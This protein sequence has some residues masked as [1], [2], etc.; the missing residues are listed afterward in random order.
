V[1]TV[2]ILLAPLALLSGCEAFSIGLTG[3][4][5]PPDELELFAQASP[6]ARAHVLFD[7]Y[8]GRATRSTGWADTAGAY[9]LVWIGPGFDE[10]LMNVDEVELRL[11]AVDAA[12]ERTER[13]PPPLELTRV[14]DE[15]G[16]VLDA[17]TFVPSTEPGRL[18]FALDGELY[19]QGPDGGAWART[20]L[21]QGV[22][23]DEASPERS[24]V[25]HADRTWVDV[26]EPDGSVWQP[27]VPEQGGWAFGPFDG[28]ELVR[29]RWQAELLCVDWVDLAS[30]SVGHTVCHTPELPV[31]GLDGA[32]SGSVNDVLFFIREDSG[33]QLRFLFVADRDGI[34]RRGRLD[35]TTTEVFG[36]YPED[37]QL[38]ALRISSAR[39]Q[40]HDQFWFA[41]GTWT[42]K[43]PLQQ[44]LRPAQVCDCPADSDPVDCRC[45]GRGVPTD[46]VGLVGVGQAWLTGVS[47]VD[48]RRRGFAQHVD[49][50]PTTQTTIDPEQP[51]DADWTIEDL[52]RPDGTPLV[53]IAPGY[54]AAGEVDL[55]A[56]TTVVDEQ[57]ET[58]DFDERGPILDE[59]VTY[60][61]TVE[62]CEPPDGHGT[63]EPVTLTWSTDEGAPA[64]LTDV[65]F[66]R[67]LALDPV[68]PD[69]PEWVHA[70]DAEILLLREKRG[71]TALSLSEAG[72]LQATVVDAPDAAPPVILRDGRRLLLD[73]G[74]VLDLDSGEVL[75]RLSLRGP[76]DGLTQR[77]QGRLL[78][79]DR[80]DGLRIWDLDADLERLLDVPGPRSGTLLDASD[81]GRV[82]LVQE[83]G[84]VWAR[85]ADGG[86][87][88][89]GSTELGLGGAW[90]S[91]DGRWALTSVQTASAGLRRM[92]HTAWALDG[93]GRGFRGA[94]RVACAECRGWLA[95]DRPSGGVVQY[96]SASSPVWVH[97]EPSGSLGGGW[98]LERTEIAS[99]TGSELKG[100]LGPT[101]AW[102]RAWWIQG[103]DVVGYDVDDGSVV[104]PFAAV[105]GMEI[106][107]AW[108]GPAWLSVEG[109]P[110]WRRNGPDGFERYL[111]AR[112]NRPSPLARGRAVLNGG[113]PHAVRVGDWRPEGTSITDAHPVVVGSRPTDQAGPVMA[114]WPCFPVRLGP[115]PER[116]VQATSWVC[117][118]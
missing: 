2:L 115:Q 75:T 33:W 109:G 24:L 6:G 5:V 37:P 7:V 22:V 66:G 29:L 11:I 73:G 12:G 100:S 74:D 79:E 112:S 88:D 108:H 23:P 60:T 64:P 101:D 86:Q 59:G 1:R 56:C 80:S 54:N 51:L 63:L 18:V 87:M 103:G 42:W 96:D 28:Q 110:D 116:V 62:G 68:D 105:S 118:R 78:V 70:V 84:R 61:F 34:E 57:G 50:S 99:G 92:T 41:D 45:I 46:H 44:D 98:S 52:P 81:D 8:D 107:R 4:E 36:L 39:G 104:R 55:T 83:T 102:G 117:A 93:S 21:P 67:G 13:E 69:A 49:L 43:K 65:V 47:T 77:G 30:R 82:R 111:Y 71:W 91:G 76:L 90:I 106:L 72:A 97:L 3:F 53:G 113:D 48:A 31:Q 32:F 38:D 10:A 17:I 58:P 19:Q 14:P 40:P 85:E 15:V 89:L 25:R 95:W 9:Q 114:S 94:S 35:V 20:P 16:A 27:P 26:I